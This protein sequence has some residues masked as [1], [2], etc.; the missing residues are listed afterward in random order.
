MIKDMF[1]FGAMPSL[2]RVVQ[3]TQQRHRVL[4]DNIANLS[5]PYFEPRDLNPKSFQATLRDAVDERRHSANPGS[6][7]LELRDTRELRFERHG[8][9]THPRP[10]RQGVM[11]HD[12]NNR[13]LERTMQSLAE[14]TLAHNTAIEVLRSEFSIMLTAIRERV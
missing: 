11:F 12:H 14:N 1:D 8:M 5:T 9:A 3:F 6:G 7:P 4:S 13:D 2:E 10:S